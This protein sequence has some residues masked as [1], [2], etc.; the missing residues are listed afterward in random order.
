ME[1]CYFTLLTKLK[2]SSPHIMCPVKSVADL[3]MV[4]F[5]GKEV[6]RIRDYGDY[7]YA[8]RSVCALLITTPPTS[9]SDYEGCSIPPWNVLR[10][11]YTKAT[12]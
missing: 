2:S 3:I 1:K 10:N 12:G 9:A 5:Y 4:S 7:L 6:N 8:R 11:S